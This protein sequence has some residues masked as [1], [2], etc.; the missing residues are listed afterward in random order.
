MVRNFTVLLSGGS[1]F[2]LGSPLLI[3][4]VLVALLLLLILDR[5]SV[6]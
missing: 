2:N 5:K 3:I 1:K 6:V 4:G